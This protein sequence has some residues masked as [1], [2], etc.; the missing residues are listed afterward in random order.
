M[1]LIDL[2]PSLSER[3]LATSRQVLVVISRTS[4]LTLT[5]ESASSTRRTLPMLATIS[6]SP[7]ERRILDTLAW[8]VVTFPSAE[9]VSNRPSSQALT[10]ALLPILRILVS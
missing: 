2:P 4:Q 6:L 3:H 9:V 7:L 5:V 8:V 1:G 10:L